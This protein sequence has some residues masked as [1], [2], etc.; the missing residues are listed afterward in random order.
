LSP[1]F[2]E[3]D[4]KGLILNVKA[5]NYGYWP[6]QGSGQQQKM[7]VIPQELKD[8]SLQF[9]NFYKRIHFRRN[10]LWLMHHG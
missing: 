7:C 6:G 3:I 10:L 2:K 8:L 9:E 5:L 4:N 1:E